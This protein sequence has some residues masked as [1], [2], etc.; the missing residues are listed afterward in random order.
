M[1]S[2]TP[3]TSP[4]GAFPIDFK[5]SPLE[6][7][8]TLFVGFFQGLFQASPP[9]AYHWTP[10]EQTEIFITDENSVKSDIVG[11]RPCITTT[12]GPVQFYSLGFDD[13]LDYDVRTGAKRKSVLVPGTMTVNCCSRA[14]LE[15][16]RIAWVCAESLWLHREMLMR[17]G[18]FEI[19]RA[20]MIG[21]PSSAGSIIQADSGD[22]WYATPVSFPF[23]FYR[24]SQVS[25]LGQKIVREITVRARLDLL[26]VSEQAPHTGGPVDGGGANV[27]YGIYAS[28]PPSFA[29]A[30]SDIY[31]NTPN[32][33]SPAPVLPV[34]PHPLNPAQMVTVRASKPYNP[35]VKPP[36][37]GGVAIP[38]SQPAV[39]ESC[40]SPPD[41][42]PT[43]QRTVK[44]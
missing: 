29:P 23:Q 38:F 40:G 28:P 19:G 18:F 12:R 14:S 32:P 20:P 24:T 15:C 5:Y 33:G 10:D 41:V 4:D 36:G 2:R 27:P 17:E 44:V 11:M 26:R 9:G 31:G 39:K 30:A 25:P 34:V 42:Q 37:M 3:T 1:P 35:A 8:R 43:F 16:E 6:Y 22:E 21:A 13:M 7:T